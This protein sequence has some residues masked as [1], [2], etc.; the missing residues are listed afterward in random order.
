MSRVIAIVGAESTG[1]TTLTQQLAQSLRNQGHTVA[2]VGEYLRE[3]CE[4]NARTPQAHEQQAIADEQARRIA[5]AASSHDLVVADT[6]AL[7][8][9]VYSDMLFDDQA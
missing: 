4:R 7:M 1:K 6:T 2:W 5:E 3:F 9:A 8:I